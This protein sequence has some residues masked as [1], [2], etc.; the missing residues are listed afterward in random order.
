[1]SCF[2][3]AE[4]SQPKWKP[5]IYI[6][7]EI[8]FTGGTSQLIKLL[9]KQAQKPKFISI[10][11][12]I[13]GF[14]I[15]AYKKKFKSPMDY[16]GPFSTVT[17]NVANVRTYWST[18]DKCKVVGGGYNFVPSYGLSGSQSMYFLNSRSRKMLEALAEVLDIDLENPL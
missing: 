17:L 15:W 1:M 2:F 12:S 8:G 11:V 6:F 16:E 7:F 4:H 18:S 3:V 14:M 13:S 5:F 10:S 9:K